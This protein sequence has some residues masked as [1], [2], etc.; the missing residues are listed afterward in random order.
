MFF[1][2]VRV[3]SDETDIYAGTEHLPNTDVDYNVHVLPAI[4][5]YVAT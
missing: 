3:V 2:S 1:Q 4:L 5:E